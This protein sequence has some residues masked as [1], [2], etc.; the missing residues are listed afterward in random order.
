[1]LNKD[2]ENRRRLE[3]L[4]KESHSWLMAVA[5]NTSKDRDIANELV[6]ELYLYLAEKINPSLWWGDNSMNLMYCHAFIK[7]RYIN[8]YM[9][10]PFV[11][12]HSFAS[13]IVFNI[14]WQH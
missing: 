4:Y 10:Y 5:F 13:F 3:N 7:T 6:S 2:D 1:M 14:F 8:L 9:V 12:F 11:I